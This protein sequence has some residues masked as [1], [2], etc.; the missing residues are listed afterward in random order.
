MRVE[1]GPI[2]A[3]YFKRSAHELTLTMKDENAD[4]LSIAPKR[5]VRFS[6]AYRATQA[7]M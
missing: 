3:I 7:C 5:P 1:T 2:Y 6:E 4:A